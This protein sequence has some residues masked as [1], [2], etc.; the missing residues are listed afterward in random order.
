MTLSTTLTG[1]ALGTLMALPLGAA[2]RGADGE[3]RI[4]YWQSPTTLNP[5]LSGGIKDNDAASLILEPLVR[6]DPTGEMIPWLVDELP[7]LENG[8]VSADQTRITWRL[9][10]GLRW[11]DGTAVTSADLRFSWQ[12][13]TAEG[14][15]C[16]Q[17]AKFTDVVD[18]ETPDARTATVVFS[19][20]KPFPYGPFVGAQAP[21]LQAAQFADC[22]GTRAPTCTEANFAPIGTGPYRVKE[23]RPGDVVVYEINPEYRDPSKPSFAT[24]TIKGGGTAEGAA[25]AVLETGEFDYAWNLQLSPDVL[26]RKQARGKGKVISAFGSLVERIAVN[27]SDPDPNLGAAR[28]TAAHPNPVLSD[29][30]VRRALSMALD[31]RL[32]SE[33]GYG[34][35]GRPAC[36]LLPFA[37]GDTDPACLQQDL[38]GARALLDQAGWV[39]SDGDGVR[40]KDGTKLRLVFQTS[41]NAVRQDFQAVIKEWWR[42]IGIETELRN[43][44]ASVFFGTDPGSPDTMQRFYADVQMFAGA[45]D[46]TDPE[47]YLASWTC[48]KAPTPENQWQGSNVSRWC[49]PAYDAMAAKMAVTGGI[50]ARTTLAKAMN[51]ALVENGVVLPLVDRGRVSALVHD[52][53]GVAINAWDSE[54]W[55]IADWHRIKN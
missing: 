40:D 3:V 49:D 4:L 2:E 8:G 41:T 5:Y 36:N 15:G 29:A 48:G 53:G 42:Q 23:F 38:E 25:R 20:P 17:V 44:D 12:Y 34:P 26:L 21:I 54:L 30:A 19:K 1:M 16:A 24:V 9:K 14:G 55:N 6:Y 39:D 28:S 22:L 46:G 35:A 37:A 27:F 43:I 33:I 13:C 32:L 11:S 31:R 45:Y 7:T 47:N 51:D 50:D 52:L 18:V 10:D